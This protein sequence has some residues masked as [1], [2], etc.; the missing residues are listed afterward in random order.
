MTVVHLKGCCVHNGSTKTVHLA[1]G[2]VSLFL[3]A[4]V[5]GAIPIHLFKLQHL[6]TPS[7]S[8]PFL[9]FHTG[10]HHCKRQ[11]KWIVQLGYLFIDSP[12]WLLVSA[13]REEST[14]KK[15]VLALALSDTVGAQCG[16][17]GDGKAAVVSSSSSSST[18]GI[19]IIWRV[20]ITDQ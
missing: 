8:L 13:Y 20:H 18:V 16:K 9:P 1:S 12:L 2:N 14:N 5:S 7:F 4:T 10:S 11:L 15:T 17:A 3:L 19:I 6:H